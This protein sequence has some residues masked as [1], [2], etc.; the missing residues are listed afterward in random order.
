MTG[1]RSLKILK[2]Q[3]L[4]KKS[5]ELETFCVKKFF[6]SHRWNFAKLGIILFVII[7][8]SVIYFKIKGA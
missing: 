4:S 6:Y 5:V 2:K 1:R 3:Y 7:F 8:W